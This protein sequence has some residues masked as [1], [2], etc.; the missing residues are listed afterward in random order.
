MEKSDIEKLDENQKLIILDSYF[1]LCN[2]LDFSSG[3]QEPY[4]LFI[5]NCVLQDIKHKDND[6]NR[7]LRF[8]GINL[9]FDFLV[10]KSGIEFKLAIL[11]TIL[12]EFNGKKEIESEL[13]YNYLVDKISS[14]FE[15]FGLNLLFVGCSNYVESKKSLEH[16]ILDEKRI[17]RVIKN[18]KKKDWNVELRKDNMIKF[19]MGI[20]LRAIPKNLKLS[21]FNRGYV[22]WAIASAIEVLILNNKN[23]D[24][25]VRKNLRHDLTFS[26]ASI[27]KI[28]KE[29][30]AGLGDLELLTYCDI[31]SQFRRD[32]EFTCIALTFDDKLY[33]TLSYRRGLMVTHDPIIIGKSKEEDVKKACQQINF[34]REK[35][36]EADI[37]NIDLKRKMADNIQYIRTL[38]T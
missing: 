4:I 35:L 12:Y 30:I 6:H 25:E 18:I 37:K 17:S 7:Y 3:L 24:R 14:L 36:E 20:A 26:L 38:F 10:N 5:D 33:E 13:D 27:N 1:K 19:P 23:N 11:P 31:T 22:Q 32:N 15:P 2:Q 9:F 29:M 16:L 21:Y 34:G 28:K 8:L